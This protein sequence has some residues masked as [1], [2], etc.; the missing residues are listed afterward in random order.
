MHIAIDDYLANLHDNLEIQDQL[1][2]VVNFQI[3]GVENESANLL[4]NNYKK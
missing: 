3:V 2:N 4:I 1:K